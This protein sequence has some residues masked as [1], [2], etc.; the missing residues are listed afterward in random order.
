MPRKGVKD[1]WRKRRKTKQQEGPPTSLCHY[2]GPEMTL[3]SSCR[4]GSVP[5]LDSLCP[6]GHDPNT[7]ETSCYRG[8]DIDKHSGPELAL[9]RTDTGK[10]ADQC[11]TQRRCL[12]GVFEKYLGLR[13]IHAYEERVSHDPI[14]I[15]NECLCAAALFIPSWL[16]R[17]VQCLC[18]N[19]FIAYHPRQRIV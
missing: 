18:S 7:V 9:F 1:E 8:S 11:T 10:P 14:L 3:C 17:T 5:R 12:F 16:P 19:M 15:Q 6:G 4:V 2:V 13:N